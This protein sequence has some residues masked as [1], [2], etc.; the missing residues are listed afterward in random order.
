MMQVG[1][2]VCVD[3]GVGRTRLVA[4]EDERFCFNLNEVRL[5]RFSRWSNVL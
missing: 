3:G 5:D 2:G 4:E 1:G